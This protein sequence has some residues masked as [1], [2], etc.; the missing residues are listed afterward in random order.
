MLGGAALIAAGV[1]ARDL[2]GREGIPRMVRWAAPI[3]VVLTLTVARGRQEQQQ[4]RA[5]PR[6][7]HR[8]DG[9]RRGVRVRLARHARA[10]RRALRTRPAP[11][12]ADLLRRSCSSRPV[13][14]GQRA[15]LLG[16]VAG[17]ALIVRLA[18][19]QQAAPGLHVTPREKIAVG[20]VAAGDR[21]RARPRLGTGHG[22]N[23]KSLGVAY[24]VHLGRQEGL[25]AV[26]HQPVEGR[27]A[28]H[29][30]AA[31]RG[32]RAGQALH[33]R[34]EDRGRPALLRPQRPDPR[35]LP[36]HPAPHGHPSGCSSSSLP[37]LATA[38]AGLRA[39][40][41]HVSPP[42]RRPRAGRD[43]HHASR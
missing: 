9:R 4:L 20:L 14:T 41:V 2:V 7:Q 19:D 23:P 18:A 15:S 43:G 13:F 24:L 38:W 10:G 3:A 5:V 1:E 11:P 21:G 28:A 26:P 40:Y 6:R 42:H 37:L 12:R 36:R 31:D 25:R 16:L 29:R 34:R 39:A 17:L 35:H 33:P 27:P 32:L 30:Q 22:Y 8:P